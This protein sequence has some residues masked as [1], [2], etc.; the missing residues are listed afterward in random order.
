MPTI[1]HK[2]LAYITHEDRLLVIRH[3]DAPEAGISVPGGTVEPG[4]DPNDAVM[5]EA[6][7]ETGLTG[8]ELVRFL[9][10][11]RW[12]GRPEGVDQIVYRRTY[13]LCLGSPGRPPETW[14][15]V[16]RHANDGSGPH[17]FELYWVRLPDEVSELAWNQREALPRLIAAMGQV[18]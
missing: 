11:T 8:L 18:G 17:L 16:E 7:E 1:V 15:H 9:G 12:D 6:F 14:R 3:P 5:R 10:E 13:Q 2:V 4:E